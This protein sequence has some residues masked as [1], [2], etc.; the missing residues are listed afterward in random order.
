[1]SYAAEQVG[2]R[3]GAKRES[4]LSQPVERND[5][6]AEKTGTLGYTVGLVMK[7]EGEIYVVIKNHFPDRFGWASEG[8]SDVQAGYAV[9]PR[10]GAS[11]AARAS[12]KKNSP[13]EA[14]PNA[15]TKGG[16]LTSTATN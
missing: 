1:V 12:A 14:P 7:K 3:E 13:V 5:K 4:G 9:D 16:Q 2:G 11:C 10:D 15:G 6:D 8:K